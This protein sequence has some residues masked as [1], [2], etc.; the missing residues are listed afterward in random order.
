MR[1]HKGWSKNKMIKDIKKISE[2]KCRL[3]EVV[4]VVILL[5]LSN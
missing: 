5:T 4:A 1:V 2:I 3:G